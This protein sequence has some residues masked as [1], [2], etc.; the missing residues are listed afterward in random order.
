MKKLVNLGKAL[1]KT[2]Q[3]EINGGLCDIAPPGCPCIVPPGH[4]CLGGGGG[5]GGSDTG[6][7]VTPFGNIYIP[8]DD[9]CPDGTQPICA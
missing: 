6:L 8:C 3:K 5:G 1:T 4:P 2:E 7:C 9:L